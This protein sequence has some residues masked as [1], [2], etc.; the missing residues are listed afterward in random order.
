MKYILIILIF[1]SCLHRGPKIEMEQGIVISKN[2]AEGYAHTYTVMEPI[3]YGHKNNI[4]M[5]VLHTD[6]IPPVYQVTFKCQHQR[7]FNIDKRN[8][9]EGLNELDTV[10]IE[11]YNLL[12]GDDEVKDFDFI[13][14]YKQKR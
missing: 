1:A 5:P 13:T 8:V 9:Y 6:Y 14:A 3:T 11:Y 7:L 4:Y 12:N 2:F 10:T